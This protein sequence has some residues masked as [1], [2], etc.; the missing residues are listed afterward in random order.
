MRLAAW[1]GIIVLVVVPWGSYEPHPH[2]A[3]VVWIPLSTPPALTV[4]DV[5]INLLLYGPF[6][7]F[8]VRARPGRAWRVVAAAALLSAV[9]ELTQVYSHGRFPSAT[10]VLLNTVGAWAGY[11]LGRRAPRAA[12]LAG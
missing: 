9:T 4:W 7:Y 3:R 1:I 8:F 11:R 2:W 5:G 6:G 12:R 10:D